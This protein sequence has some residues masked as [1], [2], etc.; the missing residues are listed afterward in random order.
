MAAATHRDAQRRRGV[1][2]QTEVLFRAPFDRAESPDLGAC[3]H[4]RRVADDRPR[5]AGRLD[6]PRPDR[7]GLRSAGRSAG[8]DRQRLC[9]DLRGPADDGRGGGRPIRPPPAVRGRPSGLHR[10]IGRLCD[11]EQRRLADCGARGPGGGRRDPDADRPRAGDGRVSARAARLGA[12]GLQ[13]RHRPL[14]RAR[15]GGRRRDHLR[16]RVAMDLLA[17]RSD[18]PHCGAVRGQAAS[19]GVRTSCQGGPRR[20]GS[21]H[22]RRARP[23]AGTGPRQRPR[24]G[25]RADDRMSR[26]WNRM[27]GPVRRL[28]ATLLG[29]DDPDG[30]CSA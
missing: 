11:R 17:Q 1:V 10:G 27:Y 30:R 22:G 16:A 24:L 3:P 5:C 9:P 2:F 7:Q 20:T 15:P 12:R 6:G 18:R 13:Q 4:V 8:L 23:G 26:G 14:E 28:G 29:A 19:R 25:E 21:R